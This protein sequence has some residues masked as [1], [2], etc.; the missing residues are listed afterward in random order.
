L[1][2]KRIYINKN[3]RLYYNNGNYHIIKDIPEDATEENIMKVLNSL[4]K[5][6]IASV[7]YKSCRFE[8]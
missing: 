6:Q 5:G 3:D 8:E 1:E 4:I 2:V 7:W